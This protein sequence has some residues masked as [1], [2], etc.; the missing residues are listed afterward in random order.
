MT[1]ERKEKLKENFARVRAEIAERNPH[2]VLLAATKTVPVEEINYAIDHLDLRYIGENRVPELL[3]KYEAIHKTA[4][5]GTPVKIH[6]I[7]HLQTNKVKYIID[8]VDMIESLDRISL[9][10]EI[11]R[12][13]EKHDRTAEVLVEVNIGREEAKSGVDPDRVAEFL[14]E[15]SAFSRIKVRGLMTMAP[16]CA[17]FEEY[18][19]YFAEMRQI[20]IDIWGKN[21]HNKL[22]TYL[23]MGMSDS[24][25]AALSAGSDMIRVGS[26]LFGARIYPEAINT[27]MKK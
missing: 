21:V 20:F 11:Q 15:I 24:Y 16:K 12:Q 5:D 19:K 26:T 22:E 9:A 23:S 2:A 1:E 7:G 8:K 6:F 17:S 10:E 18:L 13:A 3:E 25:T 27:S 4:P 14:S